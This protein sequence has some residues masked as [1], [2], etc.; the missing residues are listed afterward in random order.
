MLVAVVA[1]LIAFT[2]LLADIATGGAEL[3]RHHTVLR[4]AIDHAALRTNA[5]SLL[6]DRARYQ[7]D[8]LGHLDIQAQPAE[9]IVHLSWIQALEPQYVRVEPDRVY[10]DWGGGFGHWGLCVFAEEVARSAQE[11]AFEYDD[12]RRVEHI[13]DGVWFY[14]ER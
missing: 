2:W 5:R 14:S 11:S 8:D 13:I 7:L 12:I 1:A 3:R 10:L 9:L 4:E 6:R